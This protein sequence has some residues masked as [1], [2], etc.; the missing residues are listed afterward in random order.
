MN[1]RT[2]RVWPLSCNEEIMCEFKEGK[3]GKL[4]IE[5]GLKSNFLS[6]MSAPN[7]NK[8]ARNLYPSL[9]DDSDANGNLANMIKALEEQ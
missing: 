2:K 8:S 7:S 5:D 6:I 4:P 3:E 9:L 1:T